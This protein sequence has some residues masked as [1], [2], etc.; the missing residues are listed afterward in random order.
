MSSEKSSISVSLTNFFASLF[1]NFPKLLLTNLLF[2]VP[3]AL[4]FAVF[5][6]INSI[7]GLNSMFILFLTAIPLFPF[8]AGVTQ[9]T[10]H[11]VRG[12]EN[13]NVLDNFVLGV[14]NNI[15]RF[16]VHGIIFYIAI[17]FSYYSIVLYSQMGA[18][19]GIFYAFLALCICISVFFL[20]MF[21]YV[22]PM[23]VTFDISMKYIYKNSALMT[24]GELKHNIFAI[25]GLFLL[26]LVCATVLLCCYVPVA[27]IIATIS[28][29]LLLIPSVMSFI[30]N[31]AVY[32]GMYSM[33]AEK[34]KKRAGI[35]KKMENRRKGQFFDDEDEPQPSIIDDFSDL[36]IDENG[37][38]DEY[39][40]YN[41]KMIQ[42][43]VLIK[44]KKDAENKESDKNV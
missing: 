2:A 28:L 3:F 12:E 43:S 34:D 36:E 35:D 22:P 11:M 14:K 18:K 42:R 21:F 44:L 23:T 15:K 37:D 20:F 13:V 32:K 17:F 33:I 26:F 16:F 24:F 4:F 7:F 38:A 6:L 1:Q 31:S 19:N 25:F 10:A 39:I 30:I 27:V 9:V 29:A 5:W 40:F 41:G 8:Y